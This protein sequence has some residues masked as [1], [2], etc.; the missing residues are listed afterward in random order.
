MFRL[1]GHARFHKNFVFAQWMWYLSQRLHV[2]GKHI[3]IIWLFGYYCAKKHAQ[4]RDSSS[5]MKILSII[6]AGLPFESKDAEGN[7][8]SA[9]AIQFWQQQVVTKCNDTKY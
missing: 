3:L 2:V 8:L 5:K 1:S 9:A 7:R 6:V 4:A